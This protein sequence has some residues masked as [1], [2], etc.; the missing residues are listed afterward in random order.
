M[1]QPQHGAQKSSKLSIW[2]LERK[3][4]FNS[5]PKLWKLPGIMSP[6]VQFTFLFNFFSIFVSLKYHRKFSPSLSVISIIS[7]VP[8][9]PLLL[10]Y[11]QQNDRK[12]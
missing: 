4:F 10:K 5:N 1:K 8:L 7:V 9:L 11:S 3:K 2:K 12:E 6:A